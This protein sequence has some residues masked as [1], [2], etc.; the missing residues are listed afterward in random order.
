MSTCAVDLVALLRDDITSANSSINSPLLAV[1][2]A[3]A[4]MANDAKIARTAR[5]VLVDHHVITTGG[6]SYH[7]VFSGFFGTARGLRSSWRR[8]ILIQAS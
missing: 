2:L 3:L 1:L 8:L 4:V 7:R 5:S 6:R